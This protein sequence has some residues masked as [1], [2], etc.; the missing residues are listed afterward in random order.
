MP[1][2]GSQVIERT[3]SGETSAVKELVGLIISRDPGTQSAGLS[4]VQGSEAPVLWRGLLTLLAE[5]RWPGESISLVSPNSREHQRLAA[6]LRY[7]FLHDEMPSVS[8]IKEEV[9]L[10]GLQGETPRPAFH[11]RGAPG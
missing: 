7:L 8:N 9:L 1:E 2:T 6:K 10:S 3:I 11:V 4:A 5:G